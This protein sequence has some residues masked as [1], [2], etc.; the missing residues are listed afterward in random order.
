MSS[1]LTGTTKGYLMKKLGL[2]RSEAGFSLIELMIVVAIIGIL[3]TV[4][5]P[6]FN[7]FQ[8]KAK[9]SEAKGNLSAIYSS[10][11]SFYAE[12]SS[13]YGD[14]RDIG[15]APEGRLNY[16]VG[17]AAVGPTAASISAS[18]VNNTAGTAAAGGCIQTGTAAN[19][20]ACNFTG[21]PG[22]KYSGTIVTAA[23]GCGQ[24]LSTTTPSGTAFLASASGIISDTGTPDVWGVN[25]AKITCNNTSGI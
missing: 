17:F 5:I 23:L 20:T 1:C 8:A 22:A 25:E 19:L 12:W 18:F 7:K 15:F 16:A 13:Y 2:S 14:F 3:A 9:Q 6:N 4:A 10:E 24:V 21:Q 11:K